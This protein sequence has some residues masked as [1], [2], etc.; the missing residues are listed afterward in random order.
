MRRFLKAAGAYLFRDWYR[1]LSALFVAVLLWQWFNLLEHYWWDQTFDIV[2]GL[3]LFGTA[4]ELIVPGPRWVRGVLHGVLLLSLNIVYSGL[5]WVPIPRERE[6][7]DDWFRFVFAPLDPFVWISLGVLVLYLFAAYWSRTRMQVL[8]IIGL[9][10]ISLTIADSFTPIYLWDEIAWTVFVALAWLIA[11]HFARFQAKHPESWNDLVEYPAVLVVPTVLILAAVMASGVFVPNIRPLIKDPY[12]IWK[13]S[14]GQTVPAFLGE[15]GADTQPAAKR[16][17]RSG[18]GRDDRRLGGG[19]TFDYSEVMTVSS[20][21]KSY[22]RGETKSVYTGSGWVEG[23]EKRNQGAI[24]GLGLGQELPEGYDTG[25]AEKQEIT[26]SFSMIR[27][28]QFPVLFGASAMKKVTALGKEG[29]GFPTAAA[30]LPEAGELRWPKDAGQS[31]YPASYTVVSEVVV[32]DEAKMAQVKAGDV[33]ADSPY[34]ELPAGLPRRVRDLAA[35][36]T[37]AAPSPYEKAKAI[38]TYLKSTFPYTNEPDLTRKTSRDFVDSFLFEIKEGYCDYYSTAMA[39]LSRAIGL[40][41]RW[42]KGYAPGFMPVDLTPM[43]VPDAAID[44]NMGGIFTV[45]NA[46]AHSWVEIYFEGY[47]WVPFEPTAGFAYPYAEA[48]AEVEPTP[49]LPD[50]DP[51]ATTETES[52]G[53]QIPWGWVAGIAAALAV[54]A[55]VWRRSA[56]LG[57]WNKWQVRSLTGNQRIIWE[58]EKLIRACRR[59]GLERSPSETLRES[60][61]RWAERRRSLGGDLGE[62]LTLFERAKYS[63]AQVSEAEA[64][65]AAER[66]KSIRERL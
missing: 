25:A 16:D 18:Y 45:R 39:V 8:V 19:F 41:A 15:K 61:A 9:C 3:L 51:A 10:L 58:T 22:W 26:Q 43:G 27:K 17:A 47:G 5:Q 49:E 7:W 65:R 53:Y 1:K 52:A 12:T 11:E 23:P 60:V 37:A 21:R 6:Y 57:L 50:I 28:D 64:E 14:Q 59:K 20:S 4:I 35:D 42:V 30:W 46:D 2:H 13:E 62:V 66:I 31:K 55:A 33:P 38:E 63:A 56:L 48:T 54:A 40:P 29:V 24:S 36:I 34:L 32:L 44:P